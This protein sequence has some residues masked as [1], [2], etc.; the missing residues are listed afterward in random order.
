MCSIDWSTVIENIISG[1]TVT[2]AAGLCGWLFVKKYISQ[3]RFSEKMRSYGF[4]QVSLKLQTRREVLEM[5]RK[6][7]KIKIIYVSG[8]RYLSIYRK[9][10]RE[11]MKNGVEIQV[12]CAAVSGP[13][14]PDI[15]RME[16]SM[17]FEGKSIREPNQFIR[18]ETEQIVKDYKDT[19]MQFRFYSTEYRL[20]YV[21]AYYKDGSIRAWLTMSLPPYKSRYCFVLR[22]KRNSGKVSEAEELDFIEMMENNFDK[23]WEFASNTPEGALYESWMKKYQNAKR[24]MEL[25]KVRKSVLVEISAQHPLVDGL[26]P[27]EEFQCRLLAGV[28]LYNKL[29]TQGKQVKLYVPGSLHMDGGKADKISLSEAGTRFLIKQGIPA[30]KIY[31][32]DANELFKGEEGVYNSSDECYVASRLFQEH[33]FGQLYCVCSSAQM[34]RKALSYIQFGCLPYFHTVSADEMFHNFID[35]IFRNIPLVLQ[36]DDALQSGSA[37]AERL[38]QLRNPKLREEL[39]CK[40]KKS[41]TQSSYFKGKNKKSVSN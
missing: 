19:N 38:R 13:F 30:K 28:E 36:D 4:D 22:G 35:E 7:E 16:R 10:L 11:A 25:S 5:C 18:D 9:E 31:G 20:P 1:G 14:L 23:I 29:T 17:M 37:E 15:E 26:R 12:L 21:I 39:S 3:I 33:K 24:N 40:L 6:A 34:M 2:F 8:A 41:E 27:N 32:E